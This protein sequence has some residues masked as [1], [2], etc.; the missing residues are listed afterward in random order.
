[1]GV[2]RMVEVVVPNMT[3]AIRLGEA[4]WDPCLSR[5]PLKRVCGIAAKNLYTETDSML[6]RNPWESLA[7]VSSQK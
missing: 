6:R 5:I 3:E 7:I 4:S 1:M 2:M